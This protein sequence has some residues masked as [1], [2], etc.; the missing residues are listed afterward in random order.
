MI[1]LRI[2]VKYVKGLVLEQKA[3]MS[4][5]GS[6]TVS[7]LSDC[8]VSTK[9]L[10]IDRFLLSLLCPAVAFWRTLLSLDCSPSIFLS[11]WPSPPSHTPL[12]LALTALDLSSHLLVITLVLCKSA[13]CV[14]VRR[15]E[16]WSETSV[17][18]L[19]CYRKCKNWLELLKQ[20]PRCDEEM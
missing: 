10:Y 15:A 4:F 7:G 14:F 9:L 5:S 16:H 19:R 12:H 2:C 13:C 20:D 1:L 3:K 8:S 18:H 6:R 17:W 11:Q